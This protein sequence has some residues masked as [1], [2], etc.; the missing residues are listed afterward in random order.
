M[1]KYKIRKTGEI[2]DVISFSGGI[3]ERN[4]ILDFVSYIDSK[5]TEHYKEELNL[6]WDFVHVEE[7]DIKPSKEIDW[8]Q[9]RYE[10]AMRMLPSIAQKILYAQD[11]IFMDE[12]NCAATALSYADALIDKLKK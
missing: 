2:V 3:T 8:E 6:Y 7:H 5:G 4:K 10:I 11:C 12:E 9:R 1:S